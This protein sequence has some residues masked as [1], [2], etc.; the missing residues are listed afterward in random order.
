MASHL[1]N[2]KLD[3]KAARGKLAA[4]GKPYF[5]DLGSRLALG[6]RRGKNARPWLA[7][8][9][10][11][12]EKYAF[13]PIGE[14]DDNL[15]ANG[16]TVFTFDQAQDRARELLKAFEAK[17]R[18]AA[19]GPVITV[20]DAVQAYID[21]RSKRETPQNARKLAQHVLKTDAAL[22]KTPLA[23]LTTKALIEWRQR[24]AKTMKEISVRRVANDLR[25]AL[26]TA[27]QLHSEQ[28]PPGLRIAIKDGLAAPRRSAPVSARPPQ[29]LSDADVRRVIDAARQIDKEDGWGGEL[30]RMI[31]TLASTGSRLSQVARCRVADLQIDQRRLMVPVSRKGSA[32]KQRPM[33]SIPLGD[34]VLDVLAPAKLGRKGTDMLL[35]RPQWRRAPGPGLGVLEV[36]ARGPWKAA[37]ELRRAWLA[38]RERAGLPKDY[39]AYSLRHSSIVRNLSRGLPVSL[40]G[41]QHD[42]SATMIE[43][44]YA[45]YISD[46]LQALSRAALVPLI[47]APV[48]Q[49]PP[50]RAVGE[51]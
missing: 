28:L 30:H 43:Q 15:D 10:V 8:I 40:V 11:G 42:T 25:A 2:S 6:Y 32:T 23:E 50:A 19:L 35:L 45:A 3:S 36:Y 47:S 14:S 46:A 39:I 33:I 7:R 38:I 4:R 27:G 41:K 1:R 49:L 22:A 16:V 31:V 51:S 24:L 37:S 21:E 34:D 12:E 9:Y 18:I 48:T 20:A 44:H 13:E 5:F 26:N 29:V 17:E